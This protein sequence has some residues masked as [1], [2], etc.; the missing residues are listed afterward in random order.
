[1]LIWIYGENHYKDRDDLFCLIS[2]PIYVDSRKE[3]RKD[4]QS[5]TAQVVHSPNKFV[6]SIKGI[7][8]SVSNS[9]DGFISYYSAQ[10]IRNKIKHPFYVAYHFDRIFKI[11]LNNELK[12]TVN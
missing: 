5:S 4:P 7:K 9:S 8:G 2:S 11:F 10:N 1:M 12:I 6:A 3:A